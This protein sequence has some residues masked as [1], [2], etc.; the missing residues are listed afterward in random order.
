MRNVKPRM[1]GNR[2]DYVGSHW[3]T[4]YIDTLEN[5][6]DYYDSIGAFPNEAVQNSITHALKIMKNFH[7]NL[8]LLVHYTKRTSQTGSTECAIYVVHF[9]V[10]RLYGKSLKEYSDE[11]I[12]DAV[13]E[14]YRKIYWTEVDSSSIP[15]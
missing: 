4:L 13:I 10:Q 9:I 3:V 14:K 6:V 12:H 7:P 1:K 15:F 2:I 8:D 11:N 5:R